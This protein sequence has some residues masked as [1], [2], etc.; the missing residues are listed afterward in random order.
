MSDIFKALMV[1]QHLDEKTFTL[2][3]SNFTA[4]II[5][6]TLDK[7]KRGDREGEADVRG[8]THIGTYTVEAGREYMV[9]LRPHMKGG[10]FYVELRDSSDVIIQGMA[11]L[12]LTNPARTKVIEIATCNTRSLSPTDYLNR[13][14]QP[15]L[16]VGVNIKPTWVTEDSKIELWFRPEVNGS[17]I[18]GA[19]NNKVLVDTTVRWL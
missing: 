5:T 4:P 17:V 10:I 3:L 15:L 12:K 9:G 11:L 8:Y 18:N 1:N 6:L 14:T 16:I 7:N 13:L 2:E 19:K